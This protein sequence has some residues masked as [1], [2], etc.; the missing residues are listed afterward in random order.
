VSTTIGRL[1]M[2][3][4]DLPNTFAELARSSGYEVN[5]DSS[6]KGGYTLEKHA[7]D[8][9]TLKIIDSAGWDYVVLQENSNIPRM[10]SERRER[11]YPAAR[12][13]DERIRNSGAQTILLM[14]WGSPDTLAERG[15]DGFASEQEQVSAGF[16]TIAK[17]LDALVA[18]V[19]IAW[20]KSLMQRPELELWQHDDVHASRSGTYLVACVFYAV[21]YQQS[22][23]GLSYGAGLS[24]DTARFLQ[25]IATETVLADSIP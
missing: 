13:L 14:T 24:E 21:I 6:A 23:K 8:S 15:L 25:S 7:A 4:N 22:P 16:L 1:F 12:A 20:A 2:F 17:E 10:E 18:P 5:V 11:M 19:G 9:D 3:M